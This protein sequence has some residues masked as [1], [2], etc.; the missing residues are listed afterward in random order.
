MDFN[1]HLWVRPGGNVMIDPVAM[2]EADVAHCESLGGVALCVVTNA[3]HLRATAEL[4]ARFGFEVICHADEAAALGVDV[5]RTVD[6]GEEIVPGLVALHVPFGKTPGE[7]ALYL[8]KRRTVVFGDLVQGV[9]VGA[10][11]ILPDEKMTDPPKAV[12][13]LRRILPLPIEHILVGDGSSVFGA[14]REPLVEVLSRRNDIEI[15]RVNL[16]ALPWLP[17]SDDPR[18]SHDIREVARS[19]GAKSLGYNVRRLPPGAVSGPMHFHRDQEELFFVL[20]GRCTLER[21]T[22]VVEL[23]TGDFY[24]CLPGEKGTHKL[25]NTSEAPCTVL[26][27]SNVVA[28]DER[29]LVGLVDF[30]HDLLSP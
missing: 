22:K 28:H 17:A 8:P 14:G 23:E 2:S 9:P 4:K 24:A 12:L 15:H 5:A 29:E 11:R 7:M 25:S 27:L 26:C 3:D 20:D 13:G 19:V 18:Y 10:L 30:R 6:S 21:P 16:E 1:G